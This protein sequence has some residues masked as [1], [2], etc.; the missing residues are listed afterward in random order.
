MAE[1]LLSLEMFQSS[2]ELR[3][4]EGQLQDLLIRLILEA[5]VQVVG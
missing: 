3:V 4:V 5:M 1:K 2:L